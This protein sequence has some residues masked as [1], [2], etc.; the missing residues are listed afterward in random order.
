MA[1]APAVAAAQDA[2][3]SAAA[4]DPAIVEGQLPSLAEQYAE[5]KV[6]VA[7]IKKLKFWGYLQAR[8]AWQEAVMHG[9]PPGR[10]PS[11][12]R[13]P[14]RTTSTSAAAASRWWPTPT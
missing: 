14:T 1:L 12:G 7:G 8:Y 5:T 3:A 9:R 10:R 13:R 2:Q 4:T 11:S 6:D